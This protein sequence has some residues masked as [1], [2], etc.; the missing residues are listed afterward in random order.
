MSEEAEPSDDEAIDTLVS[1]IFVLLAV[2]R[3]LPRD[4]LREAN[5]YRSQM[6]PRLIVELDCRPVKEPLLSP[7]FFGIHLLAQWRATE[8]FRPLCRFLLEDP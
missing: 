3:G 7:L 1:A 6:I 4:A 2:S 5:L 8:A